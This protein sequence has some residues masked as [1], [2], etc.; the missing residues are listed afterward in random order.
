VSPK[1]IVQPPLKMRAAL[2]ALGL[3]SLLGLVRAGGWGFDHPRTFTEY[4]PNVERPGFCP[5]APEESLCDTNFC[6]QDNHCEEAEKRCCP[7]SCGGMMCLAPVPGIKRPGYCPNFWEV[8][9][10]QYPVRPI[11]E[12]DIDGDCSHTAHKCCGTTYESTRKCVMPL[13]FPPS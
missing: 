5:R 2:I 6:E 1:L 3:S 9:V 7:V 4:G 10:E 13:K 11:N 8:P 12:C